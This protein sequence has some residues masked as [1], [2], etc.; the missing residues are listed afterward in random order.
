MLRGA[1]GCKIN[2]STRMYRRRNAEIEVYQ[3][4]SVLPPDIPPLPCCVV[5]A[6]NARYRISQNF[7]SSN[8]SGFADGLS[9]EIEISKRKRSEMKKKTQD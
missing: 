2:A 9:L 6:I 7:S 5:Q 3:L 1:A 4:L 8:A